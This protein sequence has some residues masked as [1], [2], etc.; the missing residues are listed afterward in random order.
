M[1]KFAES[2]ELFEAL[3]SEHKLAIQKGNFGKKTAFGLRKEVEAIMTKYGKGKEW[4]IMKSSADIGLYYKG[5]NIT[6]AYNVGQMIIGALYDIF[7]KGSRREV[8]RVKKID[9]NAEYL[10]YQVTP[11]RDPKDLHKTMEQAPRPAPQITFTLHKRLSTDGPV[12]AVNITPNW[13]N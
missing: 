8:T 5:E 3:N 6:D 12:I 9:D 2:I 10:T 11:S 7:Q 13:N 1:N 4:S